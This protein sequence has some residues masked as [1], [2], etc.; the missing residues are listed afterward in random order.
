[1]NTSEHIIGEVVDQPK[2]GM[3]IDQPVALVP[4]PDGGM[5][6]MPYLQFSVETEA[7]FKDADIRHVLTPRP[8]LVNAYNEQFGVGLITPNQQLVSPDGVTLQ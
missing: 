8:E 3:M 1:M 7:L 2:D 6:F 5:A 4:N